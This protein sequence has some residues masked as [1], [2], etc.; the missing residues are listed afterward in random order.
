MLHR[1]LHQL[2]HQTGLHICYSKVKN[3]ESALGTSGQEPRS[4]KRPKMGRY[5]HFSKGDQS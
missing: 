1:L 4:L 2:L 3:R 5:C